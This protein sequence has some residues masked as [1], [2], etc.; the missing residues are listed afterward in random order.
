MSTVA[1]RDAG[2]VEP[3]AKGKLADMLWP[4]PKGDAMRMS[5]MGLILTK[6]S[7]Y[8]GREVTAEQTRAWWSLIG[9]LSFE[10]CMGAVEEHYLRT[11]FRLMPSDLQ[12][13]VGGA[14]DEP[15]WRPHI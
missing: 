6:C 15:A 14:L 8:D 10:K 5:E 4:A 7:G 12:E 9:H 13:R 11:R 2:G 3:D 1:R